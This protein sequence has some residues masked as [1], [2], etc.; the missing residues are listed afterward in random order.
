MW[1]PHSNIAAGSVAVAVLIATFG[2]G[3]VN[4][5]TPELCIERLVVKLT[6]DV[7]NPRDDGFLSS[8]LSNHPAY[9]LTLVRQ[10]DLTTIVVDLSG[11]GPDEACDS[12]VDTIRKDGRVE[13]VSPD[14][15]EIQT[16]SIHARSEPDRVAPDTQGSHAGIGS[17]VWAVSHPAHAWKILFPAQPDD[18]TGA[19]ADVRF[20]CL[21]RQ[22]PQ[23]DGPACP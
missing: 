8:L 12:V 19:Y 16:V 18:E 13:S 3:R 6:P 10:E 22:L 20:D 9:R 5:D 23:H 15:G 21:S 2:S 4:A 1:R 7:P 11:P 17:L 14:S